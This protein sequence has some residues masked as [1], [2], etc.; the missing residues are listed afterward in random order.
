[1]T[2]QQ[3]AALA[4]YSAGVLGT[5]EAIE[6]IGGHDYADLLIALAQEGLDF[7]KPKPTPAHQAHVARASAILQPRLRRAA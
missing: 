6:A 5:R 1:V 3:K 7:P 2:A 4:R